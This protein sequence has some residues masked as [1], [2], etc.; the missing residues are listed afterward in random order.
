M[1]ADTSAKP[2]KLFWILFGI[3]VVYSFFSVLLMS[4][5]GQLIALPKSWI[6]FYYRFKILFGLINLVLVA[7]LWWLHISNQVARRWVLYVA[8]IGVLGCLFAAN[9]LN[10]L[11]FPTRQHGAT[12]VSIAEADNVLA[13]SDTIYVV[14]I[15]ND[16]RGY[17]QDHMELP[18]VA[19]GTIGGE[20]VVMTYC[21]LSALPVAISPDIGTGEETDFRVMAQV[22]N[23]LILRD[24]NSGELF[25]QITATTEFSDA[26]ATVFPITMMKWSSFKELYPESEVFIYGFDRLLDPVFRW[27]F[28][29][30]LKIQYDRDKGAAFPTVS[31]D[32]ERLNGKELVWGYDAGGAQTAITHAFAQANPL[33]KFE[34]G[35]EKLVLVY[36]STHDIVTLFS[37]EKDGQEVDFETIDFR[38]QT[39]TVRLDQL[40]LHNGIFWMVWTHWFP[41]TELMNE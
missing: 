32:D 40:P 1:N 35:G 21:G 27:L 20:D 9:M 15:N 8:T 33:Y 29:A 34:F 14:E 19:G 13:D 2:T 38:G 11:L 30:T 25:Q 4:D 39:E 36:D 31:L 28:G 3:T 10:A 17:P 6:L 22:N 7:G 37:R 26:P 23:N 12:Y 24:V 16:V 18:H 41:D 5:F